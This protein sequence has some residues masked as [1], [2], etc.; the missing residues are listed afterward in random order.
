MDELNRDEVILKLV[1]EAVESK[2]CRLAEVDLE[3]LT[4]RVDGSDEIVSN[5]ARAVADILD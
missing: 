2:G 3:N 4:I 1:K 5:C